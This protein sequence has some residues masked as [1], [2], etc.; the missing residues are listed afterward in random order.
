MVQGH[1]RSKLQLRGQDNICWSASTSLDSGDVLFK[2]KSG[3]G[4]SK[5]GWRWSR[6]RKLSLSRPAGV[7]WRPL[8]GRRLTKLVFANSSAR[9][10]LHCNYIEDKYTLQLGQIHFAIWKD[11][12]CQTG[13]WKFQRLNWTDSHLYR[14]QIFSYWDKYIWLLRQI[15]I[16]IWTNTDWQTVF[17]KFPCEQSI[18]AHLKRS[19]ANLNASS[20][21]SGTRIYRSMI[22]VFG[23]GFLWWSKICR[24]QHQQYKQH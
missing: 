24:H 18:S 4:G 20:C 21:H 13:F 12:A 22:S 5:E 7:D 23:F 6:Y 16:A 15:H 17:C 2:I 11:T 10:A 8:Q 19:S 1:S 9:T 14:G 3:P